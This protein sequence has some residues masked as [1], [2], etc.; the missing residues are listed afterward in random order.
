LNKAKNKLL[1]I[2]FCFEYINYYNFI[3][4]LDLNSYKSYFPIQLD[5][6]CNG[7]QHLSL[8]SQETSIFKSLNLEKSSNASKPEDFYSYVILLLKLHIT[9]KLKDYKL[10]GSNISQ[11]DGESYTRLN[12]L[13]LNRTALKKAIMTIPYNA[14]LLSIVQYLSAG[15][16]HDVESVEINNKSIY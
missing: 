3:N 4:N 9:E 5:A 6:T 8:L 10:S 12:D 15:L 1:F 7:F 13:A 14:G 2:A 11:K 16:S